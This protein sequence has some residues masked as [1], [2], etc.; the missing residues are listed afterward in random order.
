MEGNRADELHVVR[1]HVPE[2]LLAR[3]RHL[4]AEET[5]ARF[6]DGRE[7]FR[8]DFLESVAGF[9]HHPFIEVG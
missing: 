9:G 3:H 8:K 5:A 7:G 6:L 1:D 4:G 2:L